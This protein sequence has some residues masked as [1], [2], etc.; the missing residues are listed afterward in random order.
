MMEYTQNYLINQVGQ[1]NDQLKRIKDICAISNIT[2]NIK[3]AMIKGV[4]DPQPN[5]KYEYEA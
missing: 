5:I 3:V 2:D 4:L 1:L